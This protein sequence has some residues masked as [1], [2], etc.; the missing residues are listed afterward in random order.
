MKPGTNVLVRGRF[1]GFDITY[2]PARILRWPAR[3]GPR[4]DF[5][6]YRHVRFD[7]DG[8]TMLVH[9]SALIRLEENPQ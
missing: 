7:A 5:P 6:G 1:R 8:A 3:G 9:E 2:E 4:S